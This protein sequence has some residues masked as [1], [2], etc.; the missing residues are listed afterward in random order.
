MDQHVSAR[1]LLYA[2]PGAK[3]DVWHHEEEGASDC[4]LRFTQDVERGET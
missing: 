1:H 2:K 4:G 3:Q